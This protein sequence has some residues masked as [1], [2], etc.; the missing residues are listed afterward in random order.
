MFLDFYNVE[1]KRLTSNNRPA[2]FIV[3]PNFKYSR[4]KDIVCKGGSM[5][6]YWYGGQWNTDMESLIDIMDKEVNEKVEETKKAYPGTV[7]VGHYI[8]S[9][10]SKLM[11]EFIKFCK[12]MAQS[13]T[14][15][16]TKILFSE[17]EI[18]REDYSTWRLRYTPKEGDHPAFD[19][20]YELLYSEPE[21]EKIKWFI[22]AL[23]T[24]KMVN[25]QKFLYLYG[26][27]GSGKGTII[28]LFEM[29][30]E[31]YHAAI[32]LERLTSNSEFATTQVKEV[33]LLIDPDTD[34]S[35]I[36][37]DTNLLKLT[38]H[39]P[40]P[41][42]A[43][44]KSEYELTFTGLLIAASNQRYKVRNI[45]SGITRR[46]VVVEPTTNKHN[47]RDYNRLMGL[48]K[49]ELP[50]IA[51]TCIDLFEELG[52]YH[53]D[54]YMDVRMVEET[55]H[56]FSFMREHAV[57]LGDEVSLKKASE[58]YKL[59]LEDIGFDTNG[60]K[61]KIKS[62]LE[63]YYKEFY[64]SKRVFG[65]GVLRNVYVGL[66]RDILFPDEVI[67]EDTE[68]LLDSDFEG[69]RAIVEQDSLLNKVMSEYPAQLAND[70]G[71]PSVKWDDCDTVLKDIDTRKLHYVRLPLNHIVIDFDI[72][73]SEGNKDLEANLIASQKFPP[74]YTELSKSG[75]GVHLHYYYDG[76]VSKLANLYEDDIEIKVFTGKQALRRK[77][78]KC[79]ALEIAHI[80]T[81]LPTKEKD[82]VKVYQDVQIITW[83][84]KKMRT[85]VK[86]N[87]MKEYHGATKPSVDF[88]AHIFEQAEKDGVKYDLRD[89]RQDVIIFAAKSSN[90]SAYCLKV[91]NNINYCTIDEVVDVPDIQSNSSEVDD[92]NIW[93]Y[94]IEV[95]PNVFMIGYKQRG[96]DNYT[97]AINPTGAE[98]ES[99]FNNPLIG[100][101][102]RR[103]DNHICY[104]RIL[105][106]SNIE[107]FHQ[108]QNIIE[109]DGKS[110]F[111]SSAYEMSYADIYEYSSTKQSLK[112]WEI[113]LGI[114]HNE[115]E[116]P[117]DQ[118]VPEDMWETVAKYMKDDVLA[119]ETTFEATYSDFTARKILASLSGLSI[120]ATTQQHAAKF[121]FGD[122]PR[123]QDKF[124][125]VDL[126]KTFPGYKYEFGKSTYREEDPSEGGYVYAEPGVYMN[127]ALLDVESMHPTSL[128][129]MNHFGPYTERFND[130][131]KARLA[132][133][134]KD[135]DSARK[136]FGGQLTPYLEDE[137]SA[138]SLSYA[139]KI[140]INIV[141]GMTSAKF[142]NKFRHPKNN[143][144]IVAKRG[145]LFMI[146]LKHA[147]QEQGYTVV[148]IKSDSIKI[149]D[150]DQKIIDFVFEFGK[151]YGYN[152]DH[153][154]TYERMALINDAVYIA[155]YYDKKADNMVWTA[156]GSRYADPVVY[157][158]LFTKEKVLEEDYAITKQVKSAIYL[159]ET[160]VGKLARVY[161]SNTGEDLLRVGKSKINGEEV[162]KMYYVTG[163][164][165][166]KWRLFRDYKGKQD[167]D[168]SYY[169]NVIDE[170]VQ[171][172]KDVGDIG[173]ILDPF[174]LNKAGKIEINL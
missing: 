163:T 127:V 172:I 62:E 32:D 164:K 6:A 37:K 42:N 105:G 115:L 22:G 40:M 47:S 71:T 41:I 119:T 31:G 135:F 70:N 33:P 160:F 39:E 84:E 87:I 4:V 81:G 157:K 173:L 8:S 112:K 73:D 92:N 100:F 95:F 18:R 20:M 72:K 55:D 67:P 162:E 50:Y 30:F 76:D 1:V 97:Y 165:G 17:D 110:G 68:E 75:A 58:L 16:N 140:I 129:Q 80:T 5:Y 7:V 117:W 60:Y 34:M 93:F 57:T 159:G 27:K 35:K 137:A 170:A 122:D 61:R 96:V 88:I 45:D 142:Q 2:D 104:N 154:A 171:K 79:N 25:I 106:A 12:Q 77:L 153:E 78:T 139:L 136:M 150:A 158:T 69:P 118:P 145:A 155:E 24:N 11:E 109:G 91:A 74:T 147:V 59:Y 143:D 148:H 151:K 14:Q 168:M 21:L 28:K 144:N 94:D 130:L 44:Y 116:L 48:L 19:E 43:K 29:L 101:N 52:P 56:I 128:V 13:S 102:N 166:Y 90:N 111:F 36:T 134:H 146:D 107:L 15:F 51:Q 89:M 23:L 138:K 108:S 26:R 63:R 103:Y 161:A 10:N 3:R 126:S 46:A 149:P 125:Y 156:T 82:G 141:Y 132:I 113:E 66:R 124:E 152:F 98:V 85:A 86:K 174:D 99:I 131:L 114:T 83:N 65:D 54:E 123:P 9:H 167:I 64:P 133:K 169:N 121:L 49:Y 120:N 53:Y 38:S